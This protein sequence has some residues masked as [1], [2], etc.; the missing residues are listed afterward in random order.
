MEVF[1][2][3]LDWGNEILASLIWVAKGWAI[4]AAV[5][6]VVLALIARHTGWGR[7]FWHV[8]GSYFVGRQSVPV[9]AL[10]GVLL[11]SVLV[12]VRMDV[13][14]SYYA[15][16]QATALQVAFE[17]AG[18]GDDAVRDSGIAGFWKSILIFGLLVAADITRTLLD[19]YLMQYF[20]I[21]WRV[22]LTDRLTGDWLDDRAYYRGRFLEAFDG[23]P[24]D[25]PDQR[26]QQDIDI[27]TTGT[28]PETNTP[29]VATSQTLLFGSVYAVISVVAFTP[30]L[31][32][33]AGPLTILGVTVPKALFW[34]ALI[35]V[36]ATTVVAFWIGRPIIRLTFRNE[37]TNAAF[38]Y[39]LVR[40]RDA[41]E[42]VSFY[43][44]ERTERATLAT[45][46]ARII[47]NYRRLVL[48]G[49]AF[50][51]WNRSI[52]QI[53]EPLPL[54]VQAPRLF[55]GE[56]QLGDVT[57]SSSAFS[58]VQSS[59]SFFRAVYDAFA[60]YRAAI[61]RLDGLVTANEQARA[62]PRLQARRSTDGGVELEAVEVRSPSG[63]VLLDNLDLRLAPGDWLVITGPSGT[64]KTTMLRSLAQLWPYST[65]TVRFPGGS[66][67]PATGTGADTATEQH[68]VMFLS[69]LP[70]APL[71]DLRGVVCY[72]SPPDAFD[73]KTIRAALDA[74]TLGHLGSQLDTVAD[75]AKV[76]SPGEQQRVA[77]ARILLARP[78]AVF[79]DEATSALDA[80][81]EFA[82]YSIL[83]Q[84]LPMSIVVSV[85][86]RDSVNRHHDRQL[87]L[88]GAGR[89]EFT[90]VS[91]RS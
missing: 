10:L 31:W 63:D 60:G 46:F 18:A 49:V 21:R 26:I 85:S 17:G 13:L 23:E 29:T 87:A 65:G 36:G 90:A 80:G 9:W 2:Q 83:R 56:L 19:L 35:W 14:F 50:L 24:V 58:R 54:I 5:L 53:I 69:Q 70:Y 66:D 77:F 38:R 16:D 71:G 52:S 43:R 34:I 27:F 32:N 78:R 6:L 15:N 81:Q 44:G 51:G 3:S 1:T 42:A 61:I 57:Q 62:L 25:N 48:R 40:V 30:I 73:D 74:V 20:I 59:L 64:G 8:S 67:G 76:L 22:W 55:A 86:H 88:L 84:R 11:L 33:L 68:S 4:S 28:G 91:E 82:L 37:L 41:A 7:Q 75:W 79:L 47:A 45:R 12:S 89:W 39:A 72:P